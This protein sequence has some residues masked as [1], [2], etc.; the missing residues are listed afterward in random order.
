MI[1]PKLFITKIIYQ[2]LEPSSRTLLKQ[3][4]WQRPHL[5]VNKEERQA[6]Q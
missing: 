4:D 2:R 3:S 1:I 5:T 6:N